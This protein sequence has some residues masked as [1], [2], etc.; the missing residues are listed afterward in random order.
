MKII[1]LAC[2]LLFAVPAVADEQWETMHWTSQE[3]VA[4]GVDSDS[5]TECWPSKDGE[6]FECAN[7]V[8]HAH[9]HIAELEEYLLLEQFFARQLSAINGSLLSPDPAR[10]A[11]LEKLGLQCP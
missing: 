2:V 9:N 3:F 10:M 11:F 6:W 1:V 4:S 8:P 7:L 5:T